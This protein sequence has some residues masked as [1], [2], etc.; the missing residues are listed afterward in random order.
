MLNYDNVITLSGKTE[1]ESAG[2]GEET[3]APQIKGA[4][5]VDFMLPLILFLVMF[6]KQS[7][8]PPVLLSC[9]SQNCKAA[10]ILC[11]VM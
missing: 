9:P 6:G 1:E 2:K 5:E 11:T 10:I 7:S 4:R 8:V 3:Q